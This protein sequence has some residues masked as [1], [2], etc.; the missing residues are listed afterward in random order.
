[1]PWQGMRALRVTATLEHWGHLNLYPEER[2]PGCRNKLEPAAQPRRTASRVLP[3]A[4]GTFETLGGAG[5]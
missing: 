1:M 4:Y 2:V 5:V 3:L